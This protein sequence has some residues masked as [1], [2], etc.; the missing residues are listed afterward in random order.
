MRPSQITRIER[1]LERGFNVIAGDFV[2]YHAPDG[3]ETGL[4]TI[5][6]DDEREKLPGLI[7]DQA[8]ERAQ[9]ERELVFLEPYLVDRDVELDP[10]GYFLIMGKR[11]DFAKNEQIKECQVPIA[12]I[13]NIIVVRVRYAVELESTSACGAFSFGA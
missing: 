3:T 9:S 8:G 10:A 4:L 7:I 5:M 13:H 1:A 11:W 2:V 6:Y 12:G